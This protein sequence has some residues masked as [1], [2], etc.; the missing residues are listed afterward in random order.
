MSSLPF[1]IA[2]FIAGLIS[3]LSPCVLPLVPAYV[4][5]ISGAGV[6]ELKSAQGRL[7]RRVMVN[8]SAFIV[9]FSIVFITLGA[10][11]TEIGQ[12][13]SSYKHTLSIVAG[14]VVI[15]FGLHLTGIFR[16][17]ALY[18]DARLHGVKGSST[19]VGAFVIGFAFA[20]GWTPCLGPILTIILGFA[21]QEDTL[22]KGIL[23]LAVYSL[24][25][26]V[27]F[28][29]TSL[30]MER[31]L[32][33]YTRFRSHMHAL[34]VASGGLMIALGVLL[35]IGRFTLISTWLSFLGRFEVGLESVAIK[36]SGVAVAILAALVA[37]VLYLVFR[38]RP[39][40]PE[41]QPGGPAT[42]RNPLALVVV[43][44]VI[45]GMLFFGFHVARR[46]APQ[47][48][49]QAP[50]TA[51]AAEAPDF[52]LESLDGK[53][54]RLSDLRGKAVLLNFWAT[55]CAPCKI[56]M[57]WFVELQNEYGPQ[58]LQIV[59][60]AMDDSAKEDI[61]KFAK[62]MGVNYPVLLGKEAVGDAYGGVP[63]LP[64]S[65]FISRDGKIVDRILG[66]EGKADIED[67]VKK[68]LKARPETSPTTAAGTQAQ[69]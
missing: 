38:R 51:K 19:P 17:K 37:L 53:S 39:A 54:M 55:W 31:F 8:S 6:E 35:V 41:S 2:A 69:K 36:S 20:F 29:L 3:F 12:L 24:G 43:A 50:D 22:V 18:A 64:E 61:A 60:V 10:I 47:R 4:S 34:E 23:L 68:A 45:A 9:G 58:G 7:M 25:L 13:A 57:P 40:K 16:I 28:L 30:L 42:N 56:E 49:G 32:K 46:A 62:D 52:T 33:F 5:L 21:S 26:A 48:V 67:A 59:G 15:L 14:V 44:V 11:S 63:A 65:F 66:L 1:P 27:P